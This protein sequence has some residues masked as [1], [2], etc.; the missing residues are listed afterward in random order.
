MNVRDIDRDTELPITVQMIRRAL[1]AAVWGDTLSIL[2]N[3]CP[4]S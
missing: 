4:A 2:R 3:R 1:A